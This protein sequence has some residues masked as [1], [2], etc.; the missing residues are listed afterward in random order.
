MPAITL[1]RSQFLAILPTNLNPANLRSRNARGETMLAYRSR[2][3]GRGRPEDEFNL[4]DPVA[5][6]L[7]ETLATRIHTKTAAQLTAAFWP[8]WSDAVSVA[9][10]YP[11]G[12]QCYLV[13]AD[14]GGDDYRA[15][16]GPLAGDKSAVLRLPANAQRLIAISF[17]RLLADLR[18]A[19]QA[20]EVPL[21]P[22]L[23]PRYLSDEYLEWRETIDEPWR[24]E[25]A[26]AAAKGGIERAR[27][28]AKQAKAED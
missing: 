25:I 6:W 8:M 11:S 12:E 20:A 13:V 26:R 22:R 9:E 7:T 24:V 14:M 16:I 23:A 21:P 10:T 18:A 19:A 27:A 15:Q 28:V 1:T 2:E 17:H 4:L 3:R 5:I